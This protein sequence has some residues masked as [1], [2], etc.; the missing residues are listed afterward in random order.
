MIV[1]FGCVHLL[2][3]QFITAEK[4]RGEVL[5]FKQG[6]TRKG[7]AQDPESR[8][9]SSAQDIAFGVHTNVSANPGAFDN[10][11]LLSGEAPVFH[12][13]NITYDVKSAKI[14]RRI[15]NGIDGWLKPGTFTVLMVSLLAA[16]LDW[17]LTIVPKGVTGAGKTSLLDVLAGR[18]PIGNVGGDVFIDG[19]PRNDTLDFRRRM[20]YVQQN[21]IHLPT[22]TVREALQFSAILRQSGNRQQSLAYVE[23]IMGLL[24][25]DQ[26]ADA[27]IGVPGEGLNIEQRRRLSIGVELVAKPDL[28]LFLGKLCPLHQHIAAL[29][30]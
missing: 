6:K 8:Q 30:L 24:D 15:L 20:G 29:R 22:A 5:T 16:N 28:V 14:S 18:V 21:D 19:K 23:T 11:K 9:T 26:Y 1:I 25:M 7:M 13:N 12:W 3:A 10:P 17:Q 2:A 4:S 27:V